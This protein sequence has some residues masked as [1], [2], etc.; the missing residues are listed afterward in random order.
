MQKLFVNKIHFFEFFSMGGKPRLHQLKII[1]STRSTV[2]AIL[3][4]WMFPSV[5]RNTIN[6]G[7]MPYVEKKYKASPTY[8]AH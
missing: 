4:A 6:E 7:E 8:Q 1:T 5:Q 3:T 2:Q